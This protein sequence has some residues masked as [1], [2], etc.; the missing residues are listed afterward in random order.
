MKCKNCSAELSES[1]IC[2]VC[3]SS[4]GK[5]PSAPDRK[6]VLA[7]SGLAMNWYR[8]LS[9][10]GL[11]VYGL[12]N[13]AG[14]ISMLTGTNFMRSSEA[15]FD[16]FPSLKGADVFLG[17]ISIALGFL[18]FAAALALLALKKEAPVMTVWVFAADL[19]II[20]VSTILTSVIVDASLFNIFIFLRAVAA[21]AAAGATMLYFSK[22]GQIFTN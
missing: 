7:Q 3:F 21:A 5:E 15:V 22:R 6:S 1:G 19:I 20:V 16:S 11:W 13:I 17:I 9:Y 14:G 8:F 18:S 12:L 2:P 4:Q 10:F